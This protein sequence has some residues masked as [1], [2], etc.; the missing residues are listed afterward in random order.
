MTYLV[1]FFS[2]SR[3][4][5]LTVAILAGGLLAACSEPATRAGVND[6]I[7]PTNR[8]VH[9]FNKGLDRNV[10]RPISHGYGKVTAPEVRLVLRNFASN[11]GEPQNV[12]NSVL[13]GRI[14]A[15]AKSTARFAINSTIGLAGFFDP[16][17]DF[18][19]SAENT[20]F[21]ETLYV[22]GAKE[23][24][25]NELPLIG[26]STSRHTVGRVV[27]AFTNPLGIALDAPEENYGTVSGALVGLGT[28]Y[29]LTETIDG[30]LYESADSYAQARLLYLQQRRFELQGPDTE[31]DF[32]DPFE[33]LGLD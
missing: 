17:S 16:A 13:Q 19:L 25:Y 28:R 26:P 31:E 29:E 9:G 20:D 12:I 8:A 21:G 18:G 2:A 22:W 14:G 11:F 33:E 15:A 10:V 23:G 1:S 32:I 3:I 6:P 4:R 7:E 24:A 5:A 30:V 27:D